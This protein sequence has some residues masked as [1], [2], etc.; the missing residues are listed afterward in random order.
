MTPIKP[1]YRF[2]R[3]RS[4]TFRLPVPPQ[5][6]PKSVYRR[7]QR[8]TTCNYIMAWSTCS[9]GPMVVETETFFI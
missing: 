8:S 2:G 7:A 5:P 1:L 6:A 4:L 9:P 3:L